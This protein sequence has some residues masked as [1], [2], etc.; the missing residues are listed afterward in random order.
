MAVALASPGETVPV[1]VAA[2]TAT[3]VDRTVFK[4]AG[5]G[6]RGLSLGGKDVCSSPGSP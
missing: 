3:Q 2:V 4:K 6:A 1:P 5:T